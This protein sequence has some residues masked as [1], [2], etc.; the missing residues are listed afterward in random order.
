MHQEFYFF[1]SWIHPIFSETVSRSLFLLVMS[2]RGMVTGSCRPQ[3]KYM[4]NKLD[5]WT[6]R[7]R[8]I[9]AQK[10]PIRSLVILSCIKIQ[11]A[12]AFV[13]RSLA[14]SLLKLNNVAT[15][16]TVTAGR[17]LSGILGKCSCAQNCVGNIKK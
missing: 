12:F 6:K 7:G 1:P 4:Y 16:P 17:C 11:K 14:I 2:L 15:M 10:Y 9:K 8:T 5:N 13:F 3:P